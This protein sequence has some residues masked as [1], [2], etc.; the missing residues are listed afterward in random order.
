[1]SK[2]ICHLFIL[3]VFCYGI[4]DIDRTVWYVHPDSA[5]NSIQ[6]A[7]DSCADNDIVLVGRGTYYEN[8]VWPN[9]QSISLL[10]QWGPDVTVIDGD[11]VARVITIADPAVD[12]TTL[13][14]GFTIQRGAANGQGG[15]ILCMN[16]ADP[17]IKGNIICD[18]VAD[19]G[20]G[21][22]CILDGCSPI[23]INNIITHNVALTLNT[24]RGGG[25][26]C[27]PNTS[28]VI[29][30]NTITENVA[31]I[32]AG[33]IG[34]YQSSATITDNIIADNKVLSGHGQ[35]GGI[36][37][38]L[39]TPLISGNMISGNASAGGCGVWIYWASPIMLGNTITENVRSGSWG[40]GTVNIIESSPIIRGDTITNNQ[41]DDGYGAGVICT[42]N[43]APVIDSCVI[44]NNIGTGLYSSV[45]S[46]P[47][48]TYCNI[49]RNAGDGL[50]F[51]E[52]S[53]ATVMYNNIRDNERHGVYCLVNGNPKINYNDIAG[54]GWYGVNNATP[55]IIIN[56][57]NNWWGDST[58]PYH[59]DSNPGGSGDPVSDYVDFIP[60]LFD[61]VTSIEEEF[62]STPIRKS[63]YRSTIFSGHLLL[64][65]GRNCKVFDITGR[66]VTPDK[67]KPGIYFIEI[68]GVI[69]HK[70]IKIK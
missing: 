44:T 12:T 25:I 39:G 57:E 26:L 7:L 45:W 54:N 19:N 67:I 38:S 49:S 64:P 22:V 42:Q 8:I 32:Y 37:I 70:V 40:G 69:S 55:S 18:N 41:T 6:A 56:A 23:I 28:P 27:L 53:T 30:G 5:L 16:G 3:A 43:S 51:N 62:T 63:S 36:V 11:S 68:N 35:G 31:G 52:C 66:V 10:S 47:T 13:I 24:Q 58:G 15:G 48:I 60:W 14:R 1:M 34:L 33:G 59:P 17:V 20:G 61:S 65:E 9:A 21:G 46:E 29:T 4:G 2:V 50:C